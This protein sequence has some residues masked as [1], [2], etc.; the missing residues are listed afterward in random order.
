MNK[1]LFLDIDGV[2]NCATTRERH[3]YYIGIDPYMAFM[4]G[5]IQLDTGCSV[6]LSSAWRLMPDGCEEVRK[7]VVD[8]IDVTPNMSSF[9]GD[10]IRE[11]FELNPKFKDV[12][13][14]ILDD[15]ADFHQDQ[16]LF[17]TEWKT[18][19]TPEI[20]KAVTDYLNED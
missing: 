11:W 7:K 15:N 20:A 5:K 16:P 18:G 10:E 4:V 8:F 9:R 12:K 14:A 13:Y 3:G 2:C 1:L 6:V 17:K 19:I